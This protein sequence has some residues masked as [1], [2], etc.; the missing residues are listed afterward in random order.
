M[1]FNWVHETPKSNQW[2]KIQGTIE[3]KI[4]QI[5][6]A[7]SKYM[8]QKGQ[9]LLQFSRFSKLLQYCVF[10]VVNQCFILGK[11]Y[12]LPHSI[13]VVHNSHPHLGSQPFSPFMFG[14]LTNTPT[15]ILHLNPTESKR[16]QIQSKKT[17]QFSTFYLLCG[18]W[19]WLIISLKASH[20]I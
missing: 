3:R 12:F 4:I 14:K 19:V 5:E 6:G 8:G 10:C 16:L 17:M 18:V 11:K 13:R 2:R 20:W 9:I 7:D 1:N 15:P